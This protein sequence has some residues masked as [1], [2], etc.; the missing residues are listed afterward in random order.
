M[1]DMILWFD[2]KFIQE[3]TEPNQEEGLMLMKL[4]KIGRLL[5]TVYPNKETFVLCE[6]NGTK[7]LVLFSVMCT[8][9]G[10]LKKVV[11][12]IF[13]PER[14]DFFCTNPLVGDQ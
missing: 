10:C 13:Q 4:S 7:Y 11:I 3:L 14:W 12:F 6:L 2:E 8:C 9:T 5:S 1:S